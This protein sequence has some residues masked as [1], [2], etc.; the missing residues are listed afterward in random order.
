MNDLTQFLVDSILNEDKVPGKTALFGGGFKPPT[1]GHLEV[2]TRGLKDNPEVDEV[3]IFV[4]SGVRNN[5][6]QEE[7]IK[8]W[9]M[10]QPFI[11][12]KSTII[13]SGS[14][15]KDMKRFI[16]DKEDKPY[17]FIGARPNNKDDDKDVADRS[18]F[19]EKYGGIPKRVN[20]SNA[21]VSGTRARI[22]A[23]EDK[24]QELFSY[25]PDALTDAQKEEIYD[26]L[27]SVVKEKKDPKKGTGKKPKG[28]GRRL[29]TD[30]DPKDTVRVKFSSRQDIVD[31]LNKKSFKAK[32]HA[33]SYQILSN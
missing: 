16:E 1:K 29:Y 26:M 9:E 5:I 2:V 14:P 15:L 23:K 4:G 32:S 33:R 20:T 12:V 27:R 10:F 11:P 19:F 31:T 24:K 21:Q 13:K 7:A 17:V 8:I 18:K 25:F 28:S 30:E 22:A 3:Y 6:S